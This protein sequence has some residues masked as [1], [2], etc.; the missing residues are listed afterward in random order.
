MYLSLAKQAK[1]KGASKATPPAMA[2]NPAYKKAPLLMPE[3]RN[4]TLGDAIHIVFLCPAIS[5]IQHQAAENT[6][7]FPAKLSEQWNTCTRSQMERNPTGNFSTSDG[8]RQLAS[9]I[10][11]EVNTLLPWCQTRHS[12]SPATA[13]RQ[14]SVGGRDP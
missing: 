11:G 3:S 2:A 4:L 9:R 13:T 10:F 14:A 8:D 12:V 7:L 1:T 6:L 5:I